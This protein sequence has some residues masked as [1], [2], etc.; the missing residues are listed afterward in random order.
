MIICGLKLTHDGAVALLDGDRLVF[1]VEVEKRANGRRYSAVD[2]LGLVASILADFGYTVED[3]DEWVIDGWDGEQKHVLNRYDNGNPLSIPV[4]PYRESVHAPD[5]L[6]PSLSGDFTI[7]GHPLTYTSY[8]HAAGHLASAYSSSPFAVRGESSFALIWDG[9]L[10]PMLYWI[11]PAQGIRSL[12][13]LF[14]LIGHVYALAGLSFG[15]QR[16]ASQATKADELSIAGKLMAYIALGAADARVQDILSEI[17]YRMFESENESAVLYR[18]TVRGYG[19]LFEPSRAPVHELF[20]ELQDRVRSLNVSDEDVLASIHEFLQGLLTERITDMVQRWSRSPNSS[21]GAGPWNLCLAGGCALNIKWNSALRAL[22]IFQEVWVPPFPNDSGSA[23]GAAV[24]GL[25][26]KVGLAP[27]GWQVRSGPALKSPPTTLPE[28]WT[29]VRT[30]AA[31]LARILHETGEPVV[32][33]NGRAELGPR[34]LG[35]RSIIAA[36]VS[37]DMKDRLNRMKGRESYRP[38]APICLSDHAPQLFDPGTPDPYML[39]EHRVRPEWVRRIPAVVHLD[40]SARLQ[41]VTHHDEPFLADLLEHYHRLSGVPVLCN[42][43]ANLAGSGF[44]P[45]VASAIRWG[46]TD[47]IYSDGVLYQ[48]SSHVHLT[49][50][51]GNT[52][53][54]Q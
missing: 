11:D 15:P 30:S 36:A 39:F 22:P 41:T 18:K 49:N 38:V 7:D 5:L 51:R 46:R 23:I 12:G 37:P 19:S 33:L 6:Q 16:G 42:T 34:A 4:G 40:G 27:I 17:F 13:P 20:A 25:A 2:D 31:D 43:S 24:L 52:D 10:F 48:R 35:G 50:M 45:D 29:A 53:A 44:F 26:R 47:L 54:P 14:P 8:P 1:S 32:V 3:V 9:G 21:A 28:G